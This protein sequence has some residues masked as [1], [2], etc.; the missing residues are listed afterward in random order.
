MN[1]N[2]E[3]SD[4]ARSHHT[5]VYLTHCCEAFEYSQV[6]EPLCMVTITTTSLM[7][8]IALGIVAIARKSSVVKK[9]LR[10]TSDNLLLRSR[11]CYKRLQ[12]S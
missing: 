2:L 4:M 5:H 6:T 11:E 7:L 8:T 9:R 1:C 12:V 3:L 10:K